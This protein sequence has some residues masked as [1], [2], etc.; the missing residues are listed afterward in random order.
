[1]SAQAADTTGAQVS[2]AGAVIGQLL[3][4]GSPDDPR[5]GGAVGIKE[6]T[7]GNP[8]PIVG[9]VKT[10]WNKG[11]LIGQ[12]RPLKPKEVWAIRV[13]LSSNSADVISLCSISRSTASCAGVPSRGYG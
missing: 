12:K 7:M 9:C 6:T 5:C 11:R 4:R 13:R 3:R 1:M 2:L 8:I 10:P